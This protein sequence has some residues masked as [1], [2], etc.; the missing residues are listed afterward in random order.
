MNVRVMEDMGDAAGNPNTEQELITHGYRMKL[1]AELKQQCKS[2]I[3]T[4]DAAAKQL[5]TTQTSLANMRKRRR[6]L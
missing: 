6:D 1:L 3:G 4:G 2:I 5:P